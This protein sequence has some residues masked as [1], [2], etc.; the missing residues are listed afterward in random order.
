MTTPSEAPNRYPWRSSR[1]GWAVAA[2]ALVLGVPLFFRMPLWCDITLYD[3]AARAILSGGVHYRD[4]FDTNLP[5]FPLLLTCVRATLG[6]SIEA[7][8]G[9]DLVVVGVV[10]F[11]L[12]RW[13]KVGGGAAAGAWVAAG[14]ATFYPFLSEFCHAQRDVWMMVPAVGAAWYRL[15]RTE[16]ARSGAKS[17][18]WLFGTGAVEGAIWGLAVW[19]KPH[20]VL[21]AAACWAASAMRFAGTATS[22]D[23]KAKAR[24]VGADLGG[25]VVG[26]AAV[27]LLGV[28]W[29]MASG[30]WPHLVDV[31]R[32][33]NTAYLR[34]VNKELGERLEWQLGYFPPWSVWFVFAVPVAALNLIDAR[35][36]ASRPS[37][38]E[39]GPVGDVLPGWLADDAATE[40]Q[41]FARAMLS[42]LYLGWAAMA[43]LLQKHFHYV[44]VPET[45]LM[46]AVFA[47]SRWAVV[48]LVIGW[49]VISSVWMLG[50]AAASGTPVPNWDT[51]SNKVSPHHVVWLHPALN[52][53]RNY[54][55]P[56]CFGGCAT[57]E[58]R[59]GVSFQWGMHAGIDPVQLGEVEDFLRR[60]RAGDGEV[61]CWHDSTHVLYLKLNVRQP[62]RFMHVGT[63]IGLGKWQYDQVKGELHR[64]GPG[65]RFAVSDILRVM[66]DHKRIGEPTVDG[67]PPNLQRFQRRQ[68]P[69]DQPVVFVSSCGR[70]RVHAVV[71]PIRECRIPAGIGTDY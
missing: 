13:A 71:N 26:G 22:A 28:A 3:M 47:S 46:M 38:D 49:Q 29:L 6:P 1:L 51:Y 36:W 9:V 23:W 14:V 33:W 37:E 62:I 32:N 45:L 7:V 61:V 20:V 67:L 11:L 42:A 18:G 12:V 55:W 54:W 17:H 43:L 40:S 53:S 8:R 16:A 69:F 15:R 10:T 50:G 52:P 70:Y 39:S 48:P 31:F 41:R 27:G 57:R 64:A 25:A 56:H 24:R 4:V 59:R 58:L 66:E 65:L 34:D 5:G 44:H 21:V 60:Q 19:I 68:F 2:A 35:V 63:A 30:T